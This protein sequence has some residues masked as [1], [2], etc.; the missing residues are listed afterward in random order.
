M[1]LLETMKTSMDGLTFGERF[2]GSLQV[3][4]LGMGIVFI[5]LAVLYFSI[6][7]MNFVINGGK[8]A[9]PNPVKPIV[10]EETPEEEVV[11]D[12]TELIA[13]ITAAI[14]ASL[15]TTTSNIV[16][17]NITRVHD[18]TPSWARIGRVE[19]INSRF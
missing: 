19:Q 18:T 4:L 9:K 1:N 17:R 7:F 10:V 16:V 3:T 13:V 11:V 6:V 5:S 8:N 2:L 14:A 15:Q 12:D